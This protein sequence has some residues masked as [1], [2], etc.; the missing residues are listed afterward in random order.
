MSIVQAKKSEF[1]EK[2]VDKWAYSKIKFSTNN[3]FGNSN[4][5]SIYDC[6]NPN[7]GFYTEFNQTDNMKIDFLIPNY[8]IPI[9][10]G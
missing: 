1:L 5:F 7:Y 4:Y 10:N 3:L 9:K 8:L 2:K 6:P